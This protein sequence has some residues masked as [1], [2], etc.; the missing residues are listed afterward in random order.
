MPFRWLREL[1]L[2]AMPGARL[3]LRGAAR[4]GLGL[5]LPEL[6]LVAA[7]ELLQRDGEA[8]H[9]RV[10]HDHPLGHLEQQLLLLATLRVGVGHVE[11]EVQDDFLS[12]V[13]DAVGVGEVGA[14]LALVEQELHRLLPRT[15]AGAADLHALAFIRLHF[16]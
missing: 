8:L 11:A 12:R 4:P 7:D 14:H 9:A 1:A 16:F 3:P 13:V 15:L 6:L 2:G 5:D 10:A